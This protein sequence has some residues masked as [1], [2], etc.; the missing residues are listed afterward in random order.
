M[1]WTDAQLA[2]LPKWVQDFVRAA[3]ADSNAKHKPYTRNAPKGP[4]AVEALDEAVRIHVHHIRHRLADYENLY[5][6]H[7]IDGIVDTGLLHDDRP[8]YVSGFEH[9]QEV[10][11]PEATIITFE[12][13]E[14]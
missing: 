8:P 11:D 3:V 6:K 10:G 4:H 1:G 13:T 2:G 12:T 5:T 7:I 9:T 14:E